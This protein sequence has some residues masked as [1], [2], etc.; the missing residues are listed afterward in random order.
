MKFS[1]PLAAAWIMALSSSVQASVPEHISYNF[2]I[3]P[4][5]AEHCLK[6]H[7]QDEKQRK[8]KLRLDDRQNSLDTG[9]I[10]PGD[11]EA[12]SL[13]QRIIT[14]DPDEIMP[15][16]DDH[17]PLS[18][19]QIDLLKRWVAQ[20]AGYEKHWSFI[21]PESPAIPKVALEQDEKMANAVDAFVLQ[22]LKDEG[23][24]QAPEA[25]KEAWLRRVT[26][27]L[28]GLPPSLEDQ[29]AFLSDTSPMAKEKVVS[30]LLSMPEYGE[31]MAIGW[32]DVARFADT[33]GRHEDHD[34]LTW[35]YRDWVIKSFNQNLPYD[36]FVLWQTAGDM[37]P[38]ASQEMYLATA[39]NRLPQ[40]SNEA[41]SNEEE[42]RQDIIA[43]RVNTNGIAFMGLSLECARCHDHKYDPISAK[44][45][46][47]M[48]AFLNNIDESGLYTVYT[49]NVPAPSMFVYEGD[50]ERRHAEVKLKMQVKETE[51]QAVVP[52]ARHRFEQWLN[53][54]TSTFSE[55]KPLVHL[56]FESLGGEGLEEKKVLENQADPSKPGVLRLR[57][58]LQNGHVGN[59]LD[60]RT[61]NVV[62][63]ADTG[64]F[65]RTQPFSFSIWLRPMQSQKRAVVVHY[66]RAGL[67]AG[68]QGYELLIEDDY[69]S[70]ALCHFWPGNAMRIRARQPLALN[71]WTM[72]TATY[73]GSSRA[74]GLKLY[75]NGMPAACD[76]VRDNLYKDIAYDDTFMDKDA[77][78]EP[79]LTISGRHNDNSLT[80]TLVDEFKFWDAELTPVE[81][82][83]VGKVDVKT[84]TDEWFDWWLREKDPQWIRL[85]AELK[86]LRDEENAISKRIKEVMVM[87]ELPETNRRVTHL[88][89]RGR[90]DAPADQVQPDVINAVFPFPDD[91]PRNRLGYGEWLVDKRNPL[92]ARV[93]VN[94][95]W[96]QFFGR[97][98]VLTSEDFGVQGQLPTHPE[99]LDWLAVWFMDNGWDVKALCR[100]I[101]L[102]ATYGQDAYPLDPMVLESDPDNALMAHGPRQ[103]LTAEQLRDNV[104]HVSGLLVKDIGGEP[105]K[106][107]QPV[108]L[109][110]DSGTQHSYVQDHGA[111]LFRRSCYTFWRRT[112]PPPSMTIFD[113]PTREFCKSRRDKSATPLQ[114]LVLFNDPQF[115]EA[116]R[117]LAERLVRS[118]PDDDFKRVEVAFRL[119][120]GRLPLSE[121]S[122]ILVKL[123]Q[124]QREY[125]SSHVEEAEQLRV[126][127]GEAPVAKDL[128]AVDVAATTLLTR[129]MLGFDDCIMK[130]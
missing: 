113:A 47:S 19:E 46:Y 92:T 15:P 128:P 27:D 122:E 63:I 59:A 124:D 22:R 107:Y 61:D 48:A 30:R 74:S 14:T 57:T 11:P 84:R 20:G 8:A 77:V 75:L 33:Y 9:T 91:L 13:I 76:V 108:G 60:F 72:V 25:S 80:N 112:L 23:L 79:T 125:F 39:F 119:M 3:K 101:A 5:L 17:R 78:N 111:K 28:T 50:D 100:L 88:L 56:D 103:R 117:V 12:S 126:N 55:R 32:L 70:F 34:C 65:K 130:P 73:D 104:L 102:S 44:E 7:G 62:R 109:W 51:R 31:H 110:E 41:G 96:Q 36:K 105:T 40:Q 95:I 10:V 123:M 58:R 121:E 26:F 42:F 68:S 94:R 115:L 82:R 81:V 116:G 114:A 66:S 21:P 129:A 16:L 4:I 67:D 127:N 38:G 54:S 118:F 43:D 29:D 24:K 53:S 64:Q 1:K 18:K 6:C 49:E 87:R 120:T 90:F 52:E 2:Q 98:I 106:P 89:D 85:T 37:I 83:L 71:A 45:Y 35:P 69:L 99:L 97:G 93:F 86:A